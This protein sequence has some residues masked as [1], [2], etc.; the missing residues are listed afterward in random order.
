MSSSEKNFLGLV[1]LNPLREA[2]FAAVWRGDGE[3]VENGCGRAG[4]PYNYRRVSV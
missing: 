3:T 2:H 4:F 1:P